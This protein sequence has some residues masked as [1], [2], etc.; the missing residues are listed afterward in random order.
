MNQFFQTWHSDLSLKP[1]MKTTWTQENEP[2]GMLLRLV[3][4][5]K[6]MLI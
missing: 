6:R 4:L 5:M 1:S 3:G 2:F